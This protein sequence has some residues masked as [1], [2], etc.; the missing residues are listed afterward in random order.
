MFSIFKNPTYRFF[1]VSILLFL[2]WLLIYEYWLHPKGDLD[3]A[4]ISNI[5]YF[6]SNILK[7]IGYNVLQEYPF[8]ENFRTVIIDGVHG[9]WIG[10]PCNG[11]ELFALFI[12][13]VIAYPGRLI[14]K[15]LFIPVGVVLIHIVN[16]IR[17]IALCM[18]DFYNSELLDFNHTYT[19]TIT[20]Y[21]FV[22]LLWYLWSTK[23]NNYVLNPK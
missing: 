13:F 18:I 21:S 3:R 23:W 22:F 5:V 6:S 1:I 16:I 4:V 14:N 10:D 20:V 19:F 15:L 12:G 17:V 8:D 7:S 2:S 11:I 9:V